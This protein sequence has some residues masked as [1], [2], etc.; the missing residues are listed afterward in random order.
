MVAGFAGASEGYYRLARFAALRK[1]AMS[2]NDPKTLQKLTAS[3]IGLAAAL[4]A[5]LL[6]AP[7]MHELLM[8]L[9]AFVL[10]WLGAA[11][12]AWP[13][14]KKIPANYSD[15]ICVTGL[16]HKKNSGPVDSMPIICG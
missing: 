5:V 2:A 16:V 15:V 7:G 8:R 6:A 9:F 4:G 3:A 1:A 10:I 12:A 14:R 13:S 11:A